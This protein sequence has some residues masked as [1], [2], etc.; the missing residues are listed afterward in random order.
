MR[1]TLVSPFDPTPPPAADEGAHV[2]GVE[3]VFSNLARVLARRGHEVRVLCSTD[4]PGGHESRDGVAVERIP[5]AGTVFR[6][7]LVNLADRLDP[8]DDLVH[9]AATYPFTTPRILRKA[10][11][12]GLP[13]LLDFHFEPRP[14]SWLGRLAAAA[15]RRVATRTYDRADAVTVN[16]IDYARTAPSLHGVPED[17]WR[18]LPNGIDPDRFHP[19]GPAT[20]GDYILF[21]GRLVPYKGLDVFLD[22]LERT[23]V[24]VPF[25]VAGDGPERDA[26]E[27]QA[28]T[29][30]ADVTFLGYVPGDELPQLYRGARLTVLPS[31]NHQE[32]FGISLLESMA[33]G[34]PVLASALPGVR[35]VAREGGIAAEPGDAE[36]FADRLREALTYETLPR[37]AELADHV[38]R[39]YAWPAVIDRL[40]EIYAEVLDRRAPPELA[41]RPPEEAAWTSS[42]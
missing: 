3:R 27:A 33:C 39:R 35:Q 19:E 37:G 38:H 24:D 30:E 15:Y 36:A 28:A 42:P 41:E 20:E 5:R 31:V 4:G 7:P 2:G 34:T 22:A 25:L 12:L 9:V 32:A 13:C 17:R 21:V 14:A 40:E 29:M 10:D 26:L 16:S 1:L 6:A 23:D 11:D 18:E 8:A